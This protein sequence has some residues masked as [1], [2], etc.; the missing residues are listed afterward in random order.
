MSSTEM[1]VARIEQGS[2]P[3]LMGLLGNPWLD[4]TIAVIASIPFVYYGYELYLHGGIRVPLV[5][6]WIE[7]ALLI[8]PMVA[9]RP[10]TRI[11]LNPAYWLLTYVETYWLLMPILGPGRSIVSTA[12]SSAIAIFGLAIVVWGRFSLGRNIGFI[13]AQRELVMTGAYRYVRHPIYTSLFVVYISVALTLYSRRNVILIAIGMFWFVLKSFV[14][15]SFLQADPQYA[16]YMQK[17]R[18]RWIPFIV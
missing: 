3:G 10:P 18:A 9:R 14:E 4:R 17:V 6:L 16:A 15:E 12:V 13:P 2:A 7:L 8:V 11:S 1:P 5:I